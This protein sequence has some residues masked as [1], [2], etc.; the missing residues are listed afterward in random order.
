MKKSIIIVILIL[1][2]S[3]L[4]P[5]NFPKLKGRVNDY[6]GILEPEE[7]NVLDN[8]FA[9]LE[10]KTS[11]QLV[12]LTI[13]SLEG[14]TI[15]DYSIKLTE[16]KDWKIGQKG[17]DNGIILLIAMEERKLRLE[18]GYG[19]EGILTDLKSSYIIRKLIVPSFKKGDYFKGILRGVTT[20]VGIVSKEFDISPEDLEKFKKK[21][22]ENQIGSFVI[23]LIIFFFFILPAFTGK[24]GKGGSSVFWGGGFGGGSSSGGGFGGFSGGGG[25][26]GGGGASG[27]W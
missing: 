2:A 6:A 21:K 16:Q 10:K 19:L 26:F 9:D 14:E 24:S 4:F 12:L 3:S 25:S 23:F 27:G 5:I 20:V 18:V 11:S 8:M 7:E 17:L 1:L 13:K 22:G 15:E